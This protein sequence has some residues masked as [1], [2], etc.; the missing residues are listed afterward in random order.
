MDSLSQLIWMVFGLALIARGTTTIFG[1][2]IANRL[3]DR[4]LAAT[5]FLGLVVP[6]GPSLLNLLGAN[7]HAPHLPALDL[8]TTHRLKGFL[9]LVGLGHFFFLLLV[10]FVRA[11]LARRTNARERALRGRERVEAPDLPGGAP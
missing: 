9:V 10:L 4:L 11:R 8:Y 5:L 7:V 1:L 2:D 6:L 3:F